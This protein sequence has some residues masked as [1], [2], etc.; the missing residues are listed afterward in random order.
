MCSALLEHIIIAV[1]AT[2]EALRLSYQL[3]MQAENKSPRTIENYLASLDALT[4]WLPDKGCTEVNAVSA[5]DVRTFLVALQDKG[6]SPETVNTRYRG[7][8]QFFKWAVLE[9]E[10]DASPMLT[11]KAPIVPPKPVPVINDGD[12]TKLLATCEGRG[13]TSFID[14]RDVAVLRVLLDT[15]IRRAELVGL[16]ATD[17]DL[18]ERTITV[19]GKGR[20]TRT[21]RYGLKT[22]QALDRYMRGRASIPQATAEG[23]LWLSA[24]GGSAW[25]KSGVRMMLR[26][27]SAQAG[28]ETVPHPHQFRHTFADD[29]LRSGGLEGDLMRVA[30]WQS[31]TMVD[32]YG[33][34][35]AESRAQDSRDRLEL[36]G[37]RL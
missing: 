37:D 14:R 15:G 26:R 34:S 29:Y 3:A 31:R 24:R 32:R 36:K 13:K 2:L 8:R 16:R 6:R 25:T 17:V 12:V 1:T 19:T 5:H 4:A 35:V 27:R 22:A 21:I 33:A 20:R 18:A 23:P 28:L 30:G 9:E 7:L 11:V 10:I